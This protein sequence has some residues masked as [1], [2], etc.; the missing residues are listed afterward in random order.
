MSNF[1]ELE[2]LPGHR[3]GDGIYSYRNPALADDFAT[4]CT[5]SPYRVMIACDVVVEPETPGTNEVSGKTGIDRHVLIAAIQATET[6][7]IFVPL[8]DAILP[9]YV[10]MYTK[11][12]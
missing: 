5:S 10:I 8:A 11:Q 2:N 12:P 1:G 3:F 7:S 9:V 6:E 4:S